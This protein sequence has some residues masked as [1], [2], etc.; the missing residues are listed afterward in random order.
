MADSGGPEEAKDGDGQVDVDEAERLKSIASPPG[1][2]RNST[3]LLQLVQK[4]KDF[5]LA[6]DMIE[7]ACRGLADLLVKT[8][9]SAAK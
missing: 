5:E 4:A 9:R 1:R 6:L 3:H 2:R 7:D 8:S